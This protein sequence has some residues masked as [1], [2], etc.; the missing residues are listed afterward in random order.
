MKEMGF[1][2]CGMKRRLVTLLRMKFSL[3]FGKR[4]LPEAELLEK[5]DLVL[6]VGFAGKRDLAGAVKLDERLHDIF[7]AAGR[8]LVE[9]SPGN[10]ESGATPAPKIANFFSQAPPVLR[11]ITGLC[12]GADHLAF[13]E[14]EK[15]E[16]P[17][18]TKDYAAVLAFDFLSYRGAREPGS[19]AEFDR[20]AELCSY[21]LEADGI[22]DRSDK[23]GAN[24]EKASLAARRRARGY[25]VQSALLLRQCDL[26]IAVVDP[27]EE[28]KPGGTLESV[29]SALEYEL[30][31]V[32]V[33]PKTE[34]IR[35]LDPGEDLLTALTQDD[36][37][38]WKD[39]LCRIMTQ[40]IAD[41]DR[42]EDAIQ[43]E[44]GKHGRDL[45]EEFFEDGCTPPQKP[46][47][48]G[49]FRQHKSMKERFWDCFNNKFKAGSPKRAPS[50]G[51]FAPWRARATQLNYHYT[52]LYRGT[53]LANYSMA[54]LAVLLAA[55]SLVLL[56]KSQSGNSDQFKGIA[57]IHASAQTNEVGKV[58]EVSKEAGAHHPAPPAW[59]LPTLLILGLG[60]LTI[61]YRIYQGTHKAAH[62]HWNDRAVDYR[63]LAERLRAM[64]YLPLTGSFQ[65]PAAA[66][67]QYASRVVRQ[68]AV[69]WLF[70]A[71]VRSVSPAS[72]A[73]QE[74]FSIE[75]GK[76]LSVKICQIDPQEG[77]RTL[78]DEWLDPQA[79][80]H[81]KN[82]L[83]MS[84]MSGFLE[85][86][87]VRFNK[88]V[89]GIVVLD[90]CIV[91][92]EI[93]HWVPADWHGFVSGATPWLVF[94]AAV[95]PAIVAG[96]NGIHFQS[97]CQRL[98]ERSAVM[99]NIIEGRE[100]SG[101]ERSR[102]RLAEVRKWRERMTAV[103]GD[104][105]PGAWS[106]EALHFGE[107][108]ANDFVQ[109]VAEWSV[110]YAKEIVEP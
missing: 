75:G 31:V 6:R 94:C 53:F 72:Y 90:I 42:S 73:R 5:P 46:D 29:R 52:G 105:D 104:Q 84:R 59:L 88:L 71:I 63:Y 34:G 38:Y 27:D 102:G 80:Y 25:R 4:C 87:G 57:K 58:G 36:A 108:V 64:F 20:Q 3:S 11:L 16:S 51:P 22:Y 9:L 50:T 19:L 10:T 55:L 1:W 99:A 45:M 14:F 49:G 65:P 28:G 17:S 96:L 18:V 101:G 26:L 37:D 103:Q 79:D 69:D 89:I 44:A 107:K 67:P 35:I 91:F 43:N 62:G 78:E 13:Q 12:E 109:E 15:V 30:P 74:S 81:R 47:G 33:N 110:L 7:A 85:T 41:P 23:D 40:I 66:A 8:L 60:K 48:K 95:L 100:R 86:W 61:V 76:E 106:L 39:D 32:L 98:A 24:G 97:E 68:S 54:A 77:F 82:S 56:G 92:A 70:D 93:F 83:T 21:I 2:N